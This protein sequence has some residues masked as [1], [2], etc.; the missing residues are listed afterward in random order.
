MWAVDG[1]N[2]SSVSFAAR[3]LE[4]NINVRIVDKDFNLSNKFLSRGS[5]VVLAMDNPDTN[6]LIPLIKETAID[7]NTSV[8]SLESG[9]GEEELPD[10]GGRHFRLLNKPQIA[11]LSHSGFSSYLS[12]IHI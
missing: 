10:W 9:F 4:Q 5:V 2:D 12:L 1:Q 7:L 3:L 6:N 11:I 8:V